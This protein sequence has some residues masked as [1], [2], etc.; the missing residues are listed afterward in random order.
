MAADLAMSGRGGQKGPTLID[1]IFDT[2]LPNNET[3]YA[4]RCELIS[5]INQWSEPGGGAQSIADLPTLS[6]IA[7]G[8]SPHAA[9]PV[10]AAWQL[11]RLAAKLLDDIEDGELTNR[12]SLTLNAA[13]ALIFAAQLTLQDLSETLSRERV[14][15]LGQDLQRSMLRAAAGQQA[16]LISTLEPAE[17]PDPDTWLEIAA[18]KSGEPHGWA[19][20]AGAFVACAPEEPLRSFHEYGH[21]LGILIQVADDWKDIWDEN[22]AGVCTRPGSSLP[23]CYA[24][25]T[26]PEATQQQL[27]NI[28]ERLERGDTT[29]M[30][31]L[32]QILIAEGAQ[33]YQLV[34]ARLHH[35]QALQALQRAGCLEEIGPLLALL[36]KVFPGIHRLDLYD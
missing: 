26:A 18:A 24:R 21:H 3:S 35:S 17:N 16:D 8:G 6:C 2:A 33:A 7:S 20:R 19:A 15:Q 22:G 11:A 14:W 4:F 30:P 5:L 34:T 29:A 31:Q 13:T 1:R 32:R 36:D 25:L 28:I 27:Q 9:A 10:T 12:T 23:V